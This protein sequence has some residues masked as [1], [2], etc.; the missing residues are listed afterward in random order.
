[1]SIPPC[2]SD[3]YGK[4]NDSSVTLNVATLSSALATQP[5]TSASSTQDKVGLLVHSNPTLSCV[6][7]ALVT[8]KTPAVSDGE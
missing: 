4:T 7:L 3:N 6:E 8:A 5:A 2:A 1:M